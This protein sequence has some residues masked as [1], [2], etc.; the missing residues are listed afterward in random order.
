M[1]I[2]L[3]VLKEGEFWVAVGFL[4]VIGVFLKLKV[5][6][7]I[8]GLLD[9]RSAA[10]ADELQKAQD[11][12][13]EAQKLLEAYKAKTANVEAEAAKILEDAK[14]A[15]ERFAVESRTQL[16]AQIERRAKMAKDKIALAEATAIS[17]IRGAAADAA[18]AA[19]EKLISAHIAE[20]KAAALIA[21]SI[22]VLPDKL[23]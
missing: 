6:S 9:K 8:G 18:V 2:L 16:Q 11:L 7:M 20:S 19:A 5:P 23:N 10:I 15:A 13:E 17:E 3:E 21:D 4:T 1:T 14:A 22:T 12:R